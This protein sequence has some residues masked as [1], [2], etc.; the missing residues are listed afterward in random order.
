MEILYIVTYHTLCMPFK[1]NFQ[2]HVTLFYCFQMQLTLSSPKRVN[3]SWRLMKHGESGPMRKVCFVVQF[4]FVYFNKIKSVDHYVL[5]YMYVHALY[6]KCISTD[7]CTM[8]CAI[9][10]Y[11]QTQIQ[12]YVYRVLP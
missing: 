7:T 12:L 11:V 3:H 8:S 2:L 4:Q 10:A 1:N 9:K 6:N 5:Y